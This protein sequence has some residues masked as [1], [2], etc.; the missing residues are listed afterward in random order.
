[1]SLARILILGDATS[2]PILHALQ[3]HAIPVVVA[4]FEE[5]AALGPGNDLLIIDAVPR[6]RTRASACRDLRAVA[7]LADVPI[8][9]VAVTDDVEERVRLLEAGADDVVGRPIDDAELQARVESLQLRHRRSME[10]RPSSIVTPTRRGGRRIIGVF[11]PKGGVG[12]TTVAVNLGVVLASRV[13]DQ[14]AIVDLHGTFGNVATHLDVVSR[15]TVADLSRDARS[16]HDPE[17]TRAYLWAH[18]SG[19]HILAAPVGPAFAATL[20]PSDYVAI[21]EMV[22]ASYPTV[23]VDLGSHLDDRT[24]AALET[25]DALVVAVTPEFPALKAA[26]DLFEYLQSIGSPVVDPTIV[27]NEMVPAHAL[28]PDDIESALG[29]PIAVS[30]PYD[31]ELF[32]RA[33]NEGI[34]VVLANKD[35]I[36]AKRIERLAAILLGE[37]LPQGAEPV[38]RKQRRG[39]SALLSRG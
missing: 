17:S 23:I 21:L 34:P 15:L 10:V 16:L 8:L 22:V 31:P 32:L 38:A 12:T 25:L 9:A 11:S 2:E 14:V 27:L 13:P 4:T 24:V 33:A 36:A 3:G 35:S 30:L 7:E 37:A 5:M 39:L 29:R 28:T 20:G 26:H 6:P 1:M 19:L 18:A